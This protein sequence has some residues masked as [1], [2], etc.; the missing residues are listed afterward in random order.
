MVGVKTNDNI[1]ENPT[2][3]AS[4]TANGGQKLP[5][6]KSNKGIKPPTVVKVVDRI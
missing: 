3:P 5:S 6:L 4:T 2:P 1:T